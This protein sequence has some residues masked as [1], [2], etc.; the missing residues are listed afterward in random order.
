[1][2]HFHVNAHQVAEVMNKN[3]NWK[4]YTHDSGGAG[5]RVMWLYVFILQVQGHGGPA[6]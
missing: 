6:Y 3:V 5:L 1:M 4:V 2:Q